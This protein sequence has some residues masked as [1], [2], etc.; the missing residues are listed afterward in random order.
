MTRHGYWLAV[1]LPLVIPAAWAQR[2]MPGGQVLFAWLPLLVLYGLLPLLDAWLGRDGR[3]PD[4]HGNGDDGR[5]YPDL[6]IPLLG[7][8]VYLFVL[9]WSLAL[10]GR[11][12]AGWSLVTLAGW[13]LSL[14]VIGGVLAINVAHELIHRRQ[15]GLQW[16]GGVL[17]S[18]VCYAGFKLEHPRWHHVKVATPE[19]PSSAALGA[20]VYEQ[21]PRALVLNAIRAWRLAVQDARAR[22]RRY[23]WLLNEMSGWWALSAALFGA[24]WLLFGSIAAW[25]FVGHSLVAASLLEVINYIEHYGLRRKVVD[26]QRYE[27][28]SVVHSWNADFWLS[29]ARV[30]P[31][32]RHPDHHVHPTRPFTALQTVREAPQLPLSYS[33]LSVVVLVP[34]L[35]RR[36]IHPRLPAVD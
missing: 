12:G 23:P 27:P 21:V 4:A 9:V 5:I 11:E 17:L 25:V 34:P 20:T 2:G 29:N 26:G 1:I 35:W 6:L 30:L 14:G 19:D 3:N 16:L 36:L 10:T 33:A 22:G 7:A 8:G 32:Q 24:C 28:P 31:L 13:T 18:C 15:P